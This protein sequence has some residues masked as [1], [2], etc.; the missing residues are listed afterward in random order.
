MYAKAF[1]FAVGADTFRESGSRGD[2]GL[3]ETVGLFEGAASLAEMFA[4]V[5]RGR[6]ELWLHV[7]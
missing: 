5:A 4:C 6:R 3:C 7:K 1:L 2:A